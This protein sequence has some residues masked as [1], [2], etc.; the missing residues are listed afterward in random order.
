L[1]SLDA[2]AN[3]SLHLLVSEQYKD[4]AAALAILKLVPEVATMRNGSGMLPI[5]VRTCS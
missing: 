2:D 1:Q 3:N 5:E 4:P